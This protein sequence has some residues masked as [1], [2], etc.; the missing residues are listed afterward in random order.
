SGTSD[1]GLAQHE[2]R[3]FAQNGRNCGFAVE[4]TLRG[5]HGRI[6]TEELSSIPRSLETRTKRGISTFPRRLPRR[7]PFRCKANSRYNR[8]LCQI[9][10]Q[11]PTFPPQLAFLKV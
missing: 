8:G 6:F 11:N 7:H 5:T 2:I 4:M 9:P 10:A 1:L 3:P